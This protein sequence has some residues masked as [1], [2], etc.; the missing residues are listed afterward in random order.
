MH[1]VKRPGQR[2]SARR[3][4]RQVAAFRVRVLRGLSRTDGVRPRIPQ[5]LHRARHPRHGGLGTGLSGESGNA[6]I[7]R[8][9]QQGPARSPVASAFLAVSTSAAALARSPAR[10]EA[11][12][13]GGGGSSRCRRLASMSAA[14][15][16]RRA[17]G[18]T[19]GS[20]AA[21]SAFATEAGSMVGSGGRGAAASQLSISTATLPFPATEWAAASAEAGYPSTARLTAVR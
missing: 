5:R 20:T 10:V 8:F 11:E 19:A 6:A 1:C 2:P 13:S 9:A 21:G 4:D 12:K 7:R 14:L 17:R 3:F 18:A 16:R 15:R